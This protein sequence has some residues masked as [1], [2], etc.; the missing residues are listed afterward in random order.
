M[1]YARHLTLHFLDVQRG[2]NCQWNFCEGRIAYNYRI[3]S[4]PGKQMQNQQPAE[5]ALRLLERSTSMHSVSSLERSLFGG[6]L[7][8][9]KRLT[10]HGR[11]W[12]NFSEEL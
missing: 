2:F 8:C 7:P 4:E 12:M 6:Q 9:L 3:G 5:A 1:S 11:A 10:A